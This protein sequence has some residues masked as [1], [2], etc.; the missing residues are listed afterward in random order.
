[1]LT[2]DRTPRDWFQEAVR[3]YVEKHQGCAWCGDAHQVFHFQQG[4]QVVYYCNSCDFRTSH[5]PVT[6]AYVSIPGEKMDKAE[7][8]TMFEI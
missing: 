8:K 5:D 7:K 1:M 4:K 2:A 6:N 3:C